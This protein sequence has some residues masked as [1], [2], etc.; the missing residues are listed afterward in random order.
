[1]KYYAF[2]DDG[3]IYPLGEHEDFDGAF[4]AS[5]N[6]QHSCIWCMNAQS[7]QDLYISAGENLA[8]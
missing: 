7:L 6:L 4:W 3:L 5:D 2:C 8:S 1:M